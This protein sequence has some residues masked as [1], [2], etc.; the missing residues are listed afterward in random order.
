MACRTAW[1]RIHSRK[2]I[3]LFAKAL[4][5]LLLVPLLSGWMLRYGSTLFQLYNRPAY[6]K[7]MFLEFE[8]SWQL[9]TRGDKSLL[10]VDLVEK[11][12]KRIRSQDPK[13]IPRRIGPFRSLFDDRMFKG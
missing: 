1:W 3:R 8:Q 4:P 11:V 10:N 2:S 13:E 7:L 12:E 6:Y 5:I 9:S